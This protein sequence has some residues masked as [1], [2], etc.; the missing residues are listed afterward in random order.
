MR[1]DGHAIHRAQF[2]AGLD[3]GQRRGRMRQHFGDL[4]LARRLV[5]RA[6]EAQAELAH[7]AASAAPAAR[8]RRR[9]S[10]VRRVQLADHHAQNARASR[11]ACGRLNQRRVGLAHRVPI[12]AVIL[13]VV[14]V[15]ALAR[16]GLFEHRHLFLGEI[17]IHFGV[18][19]DRCAPGDCRRRW[20]SRARLPG[21]RPLSNPARIARA[22]CRRAWWSTGAAGP[23][24]PP[25]PPPPPLP[26]RPPPVFSIE[27]TDTDSAGPPR[28]PRTA[29]SFPSG[30]ICGLETS[31][32]SG[33]MEMRSRMSSK[34]ISTFT[35]GLARRHSPRSPPRPHRARR[36]VRWSPA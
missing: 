3:L 30:L 11:P 35:G 2:F 26:P 34:S 10:R 1:P 16:P 24:S 21:S 23:P 7:H 29:D 6:V 36:R 19:V 32:P 17:D 27:D 31:R 5:F 12:R 15:I 9:N 8:R 25:R 4:Q 22:A 18:D 33:S 13:R 20:R 14:V 28:S